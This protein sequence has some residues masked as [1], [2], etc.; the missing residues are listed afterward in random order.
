MSY[1][2]LMMYK[3]FSDDENCN[4]LQKITKDQLTEKRQLL[5]VKRLHKQLCK[6]KKISYHGMGLIKETISEIDKGAREIVF[7]NF[8]NDS[9]NL[10]QEQVDDIVDY[11]NEENDGKIT[12][13]INFTLV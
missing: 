8:N 9:I 11:L 2:A 10:L 1:E 3:N 5:Q 4:R 12:K 6:L 13:N 7:N